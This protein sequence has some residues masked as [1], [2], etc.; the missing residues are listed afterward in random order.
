VTT[1]KG[2]VTALYRAGKF[3]EAVPLA[4]RVLAIR[5]KALGAD[6]P[7]VAASLNN[8]ALLYANQG[9]YADAEPLYKPALAIREKALGPN[10]PDI[11]QSLNNLALLYHNQGRY[12]DAEP[13]S[14]QRLPLRFSAT[15]GLRIFAWRSDILLERRNLQ[16]ENKQHRLITHLPEFRRH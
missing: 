14:H 5:E 3:A 7:D 11:A 1:L 16:T 9:R 8:L 15:V 10:H 4:Q 6:H 12:A 2:R 13:P